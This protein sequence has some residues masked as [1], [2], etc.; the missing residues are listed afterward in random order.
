MIDEIKIDP[1]ELSRWQGRVDGHLDSL[2]RRVGEVE[3]KID[4]L[5]DKIEKRME[6]VIN[7]RASNERTSSVTFKWILEKIAL[8]ILISGGSVAATIYVIIQAVHNGS[9]GGLP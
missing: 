3:T 1:I 8:P 5:P 6:K 4:A 9:L 7:G 2:D